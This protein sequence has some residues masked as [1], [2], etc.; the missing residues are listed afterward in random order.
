MHLTYAHT[1]GSA[2]QDGE[3]KRRTGLFSLPFMTRAAERQQQQ[4]QQEAAA[5]LQQLEAEDA[6]AAASSDAEPEGD[7]SPAWGSGNRGR[8]SFGSGPSLRQMVRTPLWPA[9]CAL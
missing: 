4:A 1:A 9:R 5:V 7:D 8:M 3:A 2:N 6:A